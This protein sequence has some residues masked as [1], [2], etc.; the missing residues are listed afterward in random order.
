MKKVNSSLCSIFML[1]ACVFSVQTALAVQVPLK[2]G[3]IGIGTMM[4]SRSVS[5]IPV[6]VSLDDTDLG[7]SF[8]KPVGVAQITIEDQNGT[9]V[10]QDVLDTNSTHATDIETGGFDSGNYTV[11]ISYGST[12]LV[13]AF[14]L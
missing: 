1:L 12:N 14:Q 4:L 11:K 9:V 10:Y 7:I 2:K 13:G 3:D 6:S 8:D 5:A